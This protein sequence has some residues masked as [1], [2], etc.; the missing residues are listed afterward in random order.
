MAKGIGRNRSAFHDYEVLEKVEAGIVLLGSEVKSLRDGRVTMRDSYARFD[1]HGELWLINLDIAPYTHA[2]SGGHEPKRKRK[3]LLRRRE[4]R[5]LAGKVEEK[6]LTLAPL[7]M[8]FNSRGIAKV[9]V[10]LCRGRRQFDK[11][12]AVKE[13]DHKRE[14]QRAMAARRRE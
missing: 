10:G 4:L 6:G 5:R 3:L 11:R 13:R 1:P 2:L 9:E 7:G 12:Q 14:M 8:H